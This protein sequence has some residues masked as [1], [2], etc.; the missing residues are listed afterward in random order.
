MALAIEMEGSN[1]F[2]GW[3]EEEREG[4]HKG[5]KRGGRIP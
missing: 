1:D 3:P 2:I 5:A 4:K